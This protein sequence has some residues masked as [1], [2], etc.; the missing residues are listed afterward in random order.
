[1]VIQWCLKGISER[2]TFG[3]TEAEALL[4]SGIKSSWLFNNPTVPIELA[5]PTVQ[6]LLGLTALLTHVNNYAAVRTTSPYISLSAGVVLRD[7]AVGTRKFPAWR[8]AADFATEWG[9]SPGY[10]YRL[11]TIVSPK[12]A[13]EIMNVSDEL[14]NLN[15]FDAAWKYQKQGEVTAKLVI[16][17]VQIEYVMKV[18]SDRIPTGFRRDNSRF[19]KPET[20]S[21][22]LVEI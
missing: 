16:P 8:S 3:D 11:W 12:P 2:P 18:G 5:I 13:P 9:R 21:N 14:R 22:L 6:G 20:I 10:V 19:V 15:L 4:Y 17:P 1:M 7:T